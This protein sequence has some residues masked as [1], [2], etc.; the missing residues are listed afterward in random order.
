MFPIFNQQTI[1]MH[2]QQKGSKVKHTT[3]LITIQIHL[4]LTSPLWKPR[5][6][7]NLK[8]LIKVKCTQLFGLVSFMT[9][10]NLGKEH[11]D[12]GPCHTAQLSMQTCFWSIFMKYLHFSQISGLGLWSGFHLFSSSVQF[13]SLWL[14]SSVQRGEIYVL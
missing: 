9:L 14:L 13:L 2:L 3:L 8:R 6:K 10:V 1:I 11:L 12:S 4:N 5:K 7:Q